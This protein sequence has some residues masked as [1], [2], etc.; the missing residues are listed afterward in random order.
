LKRR[1]ENGDAHFTMSVILR[2][3]GLLKE[4]ALECERARNLDPTNSGWRS[5]S[6]PFLF[7]GDLPRAKQ[8]IALDSGSSWSRGMTLVILLR[9]GDRAELLRF[10]DAASINDFAPAD[11][12]FWLLLRASFTHAPQHEIDERA[13]EVMNYFLP[14]RDAEWIF[15]GSE[16]L[17]ATGKNEDALRLLRKVVEKNYCAYPAMDTDPAFDTIRN[18]PEFSKIRQAG[19]ACQQRFLQFRSQVASK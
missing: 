2:F 7:L 1:P 9:K 3:A 6:I 4:S 5:C 16:A 13:A 8:Y 18:T 10:G 11:A 15:G 19:I 14:L 17:A 12:Q